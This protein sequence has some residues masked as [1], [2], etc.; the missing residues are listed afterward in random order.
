M[1]PKRRRPTNRLLNVTATGLVLL[2]VANGGYIVYLLGNADPKIRNYCA[3]RVES[4]TI[5][6]RYWRCVLAHWKATPRG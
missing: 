3:Q 4:E 6:I 1:P 2:T 5:S